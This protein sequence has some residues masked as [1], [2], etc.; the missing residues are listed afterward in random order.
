MRRDEPLALSPLS[1]AILSTVSLVGAVLFPLLTYTF[2]LAAFGIAHVA[3]EMR[4]VDMRFSSRMP[5]RP[6]LMITVILA[7][8]VVTRVLT[9][10]GAVA[11]DTTRVVELL[12]VVG[13]ASIP[14]PML[15]DRGG[16]RAATGLAICAL[17][18][19][20]L[21]ISPLA[22]MLT[23][24]V[25]HNATPVGFLVEAAAP[26]H[27]RRVLSLSL[28]VFV[29]LPLAIASGVPA[30][31]ADALGMRSLSFSPFTVGALAD[32]FKVY[33]PPA[34]ASLSSAEHLFSGI[35]FAQCM[36]YVA[37]LH[38]MPRLVDQD[39]AQPIVG[40]PR[41]ALFVVI[42]VVVG[43]AFLAGFA[44]D[45]GGARSIYGVFAAVHAWIEV[46]ILLYALV[47]DGGQGATLAHTST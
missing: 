4:Y 42:L 20:S 3:A 2:S 43:G 30:Y 40:W 39:E 24:A 33:L 5:R 45:F 47:L 29:G 8:V 31:F 34:I 32:H 26:A 6:L 15:L 11:S 23:L 17:L 9:L 19:I 13:L 44:A 38:V 7:L 35:V 37:V 1:I 27:R 16:P 28:L 25:V 12:L 22:G 41:P 46:P 36:H 21:A 18:V 14:L 10:T